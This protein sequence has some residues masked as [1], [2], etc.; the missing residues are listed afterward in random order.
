MMSNTCDLLLDYFNNQLTKEQEEEFELHLLECEE[1]QE[2]LAELQQL[3]ED[4][5]Y[6]SEAIDPPSGM[7]QRVL[8]NVINGTN[9]PETEPEP[10]K[11][12]QEK[13]TSI[14]E[15]NE[16]SRS[17]KKSW[18]KPLIAAVLTLSLIGNGAALI[19]LSNDEE[20]SPT[21]KPEETEPSLDTIQKMLSLSPSEGVNAEATA[22]MIEQNNKTNLV[23]QASDLPELEGEETYQVWVL[24]D[25]KPYRAGTFVSNANGNGAVS[26]LMNYQGK[27]QFDTIAITKE[28]NANSQKPKG[29][30]LL[31]SPI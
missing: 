7:K 1:C 2:E 18:Y 23:I 27:H 25:G 4:L 17:K 9:T 19:Y 21:T 13:V 6:S 29:D 26:Y 12:E 3:T 20:T 8:S 15:W 11:Q 22:M 14:N 10:E 5:P 28:P 24:E 31:S 16:P 30:I